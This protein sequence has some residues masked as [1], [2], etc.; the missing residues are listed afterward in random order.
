M[1]LLSDMDGN[2]YVT[3]KTGSTIT[4]TDLMRKVVK[5]DGRPHSHIEMDAGLGYGVLSYTLRNGTKK[6]GTVRTALLVLIAL[7]YEV[8]IGKVSND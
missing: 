8:Q 5:K 2:F 3:D 7:G 1:R 6:A 4:L